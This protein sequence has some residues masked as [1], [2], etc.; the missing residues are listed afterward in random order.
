MAAP[1]AGTAGDFII[2]MAGLDT[3]DM[4]AVP[5]DAARPQ[6]FCRQFSVRLFDMFRLL[7]RGDPPPQRCG[8]TD[9]KGHGP[10]AVWS[11]NADS[12]KGDDMLEA[13]VLLKR[14]GDLARAR[15]AANMQT[16]TDPSQ[17]KEWKLILKR[18]DRLAGAGPATRRRRVR[19]SGGD[20]GRHGDRDASGEGGSV[21]QMSLAWE[22]L[23]AD[24]LVMSLLQVDVA[25]AA[26]DAV[27]VRAFVNDSCI[28]ADEP[29]FSAR[30]QQSGRS[31]HGEI[32]SLDRPGG[33]QA[34]RAL[35]NHV[36]RPLPI[37]SNPT[38]HARTRTMP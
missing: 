16:L 34:R 23:S 1:R 10:L 33:G 14:F 12:C 9:R 29:F 24:V 36:V 31:G 22:R 4:S 8:M 25:R 7:W 15:V 37:T 6:L 26:P 17:I 28:V 20:G 19:G 27:E 5:A 2:R 21:Q 11:F 3:I 18:L 30:E 35:I 13:G 32:S 38:P